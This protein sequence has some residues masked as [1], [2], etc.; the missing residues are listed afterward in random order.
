MSEQNLKRNMLWN[1][2]GNLLYVACQWVVTVLVTKLGNFYDAGVLSVAMSVTATF[3][4]LALFGI[5]NF[6]VSDA[7]GKYSD[8][9]YVGFRL[10]TCTVALVGCMGF[11]LVVRYNAEQLLAILWFMMF[12]LSENF[13]DVLHGIA[14]KRDRLDIAGKSFAAKG[15]GLLAVFVLCY[16]LTGSLNLGLFAMAALSWSVTL[17]YDVFRV[18]RLASFALTERKLQWFSLAKETVPLCVYLFLNAAIISVP[19]LIL[20]EVCGEELLGA[21][22]SI[23]APALLIPVVLG[24]VYN[25]FAQIFG[26]HCK[27]K[28]RKA[29]LMLMAKLCAAIAAISALMMLAA[30][31]L[32]DWALVL[33]FGDPIRPYVSFFMPI[34]LAMAVCAFFSFFC[35]LATVL[36]DFVWLVGACAAG[37]VTEL[38]VTSVWIDAVGINATSYSCSVAALIASVILLVRILRILLSKRKWRM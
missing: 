1:G 4:T 15:V 34:L 14:Q 7:E 19:K 26:E 24:Y 23:Y 31:F 35:M 32:G 3:R 17:F 5:R 8:T 9:C 13:S 10:I 22:S 30:A 29:F 33:V 20:G 18:R 27:T 28:D 36:R 38:A 25:P 12:H 16:R 37:F 6:Q 21:Y 11:S 2:V